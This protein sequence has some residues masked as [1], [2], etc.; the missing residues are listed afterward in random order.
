MQQQRIASSRLYFP[1]GKCNSE[2]H[3]NLGKRSQLLHIRNLQCKPNAL[4]LASSRALLRPRSA[5]RATQLHVLLCADHRPP[6]MAVL[7]DNLRPENLSRPEWSLWC[8]I[9]HANE[10]HPRCTLA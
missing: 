9:G 4:S 7:N 2:Q 8:N 10:Q 1:T 5:T 6:G 3:P